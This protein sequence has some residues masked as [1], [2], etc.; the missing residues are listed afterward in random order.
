M[1]LVMLVCPIFCSIDLNP[2]L[3]ALTYQLDLDI[4]SVYL[5][6]KM[7]FLVMSRLSKV[8]VWTGQTVKHR[9]MR[10]NALPQLH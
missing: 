9:Q 6:T 5:H 7:K 8:R 10:L 3:M 2:D 1:Y 4:L